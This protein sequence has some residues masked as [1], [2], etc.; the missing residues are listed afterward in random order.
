[1]IKNK[2]IL[3][4]GGTGSLGTALVSKL[5]NDNEIIVFSR[6]EAKQYRMQ[7]MFPNINYII[8][9]IRNYEKVRKTVKNVNP[10]IVINA[11]AMKHI[12]ICEIYP[13]EAL[14]TNTIGTKN[15]VESCSEL[16]I[17]AKILSISTDKA[18]NPVCA[19]GMTKSLQERI[20]LNGLNN[21]FNCV[22]YG[23]LLEST[24]SVIPFFRQ[25]IKD[26]QN[27]PITDIN[28]TRF[29]LTLKQ[30][31]N[32]ILEVLKDKEGKK[33][34][35]PIIPSIKITDLA[36]IMLKNT[37]LNTYTVGVRPG[38]KID[39]VL[40]SKEETIRTKRH[41]NSYIIYDV[42]LNKKFNDIS[43]EYLSNQNLMEINDLYYFIKE[44][45][46]I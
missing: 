39:E 20:H 8:G 1:M 25:K 42:K 3:I 13:Y 16:L 31:T 29:F 43:E 40:I 35:V 5:S 22:R 21:V 17:N 28:M 14:L 34:F 12:T 19:Y 24:G 41:N 32:F 10:D 36:N 37:N 44:N 9:D 45:N 33:I 4:F 26:K 15:L 2:K 7:L 18:C 6:D 46:I 23:N 30:A 11:A 38:E 27:L